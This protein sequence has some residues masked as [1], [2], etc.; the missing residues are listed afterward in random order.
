M[1]TFIF[2]LV[3]KN[4]DIESAEQANQLDWSKADFYASQIDGQTTL[5]V[6]S[7]MEVANRVEFALDAIAFLNGLNPAIEVLAVAPDLVGPSDIAARAGIDRETI[8][9]WANASRGRGDF[10]T[11]LARLG[12][13]RKIWDWPTV[14]RWLK[15][16]NR[17]DSNEVGLTRNEFSQLDALLMAGAGRR[18]RQPN[19]KQ[20]PISKTV[21]QIVPSDPVA[22][23]DAIADLF[24]TSNFKVTPGITGESN[25]GTEGGIRNFPTSTIVTDASIYPVVN[26]YQLAA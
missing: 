12:G 26:N 8:R 19:M 15:E 16:N 5:T 24:A 22:L 4:L 7:A 3:V 18:T 9:T 17:F 11:P 13:D 25:R 20:G 23:A 21:A 14:N 1:D 10:P 2:T 6:A